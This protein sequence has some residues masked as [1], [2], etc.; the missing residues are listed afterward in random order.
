LKDKFFHKTNPLVL[1]NDQKR[2]T[3]PKPMGMPKS[4]QQLLK[5]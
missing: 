1:V 5:K 2:F 3:K 4:P